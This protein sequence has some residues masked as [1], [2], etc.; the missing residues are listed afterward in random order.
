A[1]AVGIAV[2]DIII[3]YAGKPTP[4]FPTLNAAVGAAEGAVPIVVVREGGEVPLSVQKGRIGVSL[5]PVVKGTP[6][7]PLPKATVTKLDFSSLADRPHDSWFVFFREGERSGFARIRA[8]LIGHRLIVLTEEVFEDETG[9]MDHEVTCVTTSD[10]I[11]MVRMT[12][13]RDRMND[14]ER[15]GSACPCGE[16]KFRWTVLSRGPGSDD[17]VFQVQIGIGV[18]PAYMM[19]TLASFM[20]REEGACLRFKPLFEGS[21][22]TGLPSAL[23]C[24]KKE[25]VTVGGE[26]MSAWRFEWRTL[27]VPEGGTVYWLDDAGQLLRISSGEIHVEATTADDV[28]NGQPESVISR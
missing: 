8:R 24:V 27:G 14:W 6:G 17:E 1:E 5:L 19:E 22:R 10:G 9:I 2:G 26:E 16:G 4:D 7:T 11:P 23:V 15:F 21:G 3:S 28:M 25:K 20:P 13:F 18:I 12:A